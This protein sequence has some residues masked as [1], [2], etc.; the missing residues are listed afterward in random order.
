LT[1]ERFAMSLS[2]I[3]FFGAFGLI[4]SA[5]AGCTAQPSSSEATTSSVAAALTGETFRL[6]DE[7]NTEPGGRCDVHTVLTFA[8]EE[9]EDSNPEAV[10][11]H[12]HLRDTLVGDCRRAV[13]PD[14]R[15]YVLRLEDVS[16]GSKIYTARLTTEGTPRFISV[17]DH[18][19]RICKDL[20]P[21][22]IIVTEDSLAGDSRTLYSYDGPAIENQQ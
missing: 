7:P 18:S 8:P 11:R 6:Y 15:T 10:V 22:R 2:H 20:V 4:L 1:K 9:H 12:A 17:T 13:D 5:T 3:S 14:P 16:C 19:T 21:A